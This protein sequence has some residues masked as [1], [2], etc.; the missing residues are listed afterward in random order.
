MSPTSSRYL[1]HSARLRPVVLGDLAVLEELLSLSFA[2]GGP[3]GACVLSRRTWHQLESPAALVGQ[4]GIECGSLPSLVGFAPGRSA[5]PFSTGV[6]TTGR[7]L[8]DDQAG[9]GPTASPLDSADH[10]ADAS[11]CTRSRISRTPHGCASAQRVPR[12]IALHPRLDR[13]TVLRSLI[14]KR[15]RDHSIPGGFARRTTTRSLAGTPCPLR[16][17]ACRCARYAVPWCRRASQEGAP[18]V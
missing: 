17:R 12:G 14:H 18:Q 10:R 16:S 8:R 15:P 11:T 6:I 5:D 2:R 4:R 9:S 13:R 7:R 1:L 3:G